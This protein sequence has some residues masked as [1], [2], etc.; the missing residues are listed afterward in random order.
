[1]EGHIRMSTAAT[2]HLVT[3]VVALAAAIVSVAAL[4]IAL[5]GPS[6]A[7]TN[8]A[9]HQG[10]GYSV[11]GGDFVGYYVTTAGTKVY[12]LSPRKALPSGISLHTAA[13]YPGVSKTASRQLAYALNRWGN[14]S[15]SPAAAAE[16]QLVNTI[17]GNAS[18]VAR[19][20]A[21]LPKSVASLVS[22]HLALTRRFYG[23]YDTAVRTPTALLPGQSGTGSVVITS[24][25]GHRVSGVTVL[26]TSSKNGAVPKRITT[27]SK[28]IG[29]FTY[30]ATDVGEV[31]I[32]AMAID[33]PATAVQVN[34]PSPT[35][36][37]M[38]SP[39]SLV[40]SRGSA[41]FRKSP[42][43]FSHS[44][45]CT[46]TCNGKPATTLSACAP[47]SSRA[48][49]IGF[50]Y[51]G[52][53]VYVTFAHS[54]K[55]ACKSRSVTTKDG[56]RVTAGWQFKTSHGW[57]AV[58]AAAGSFVVDCPAVPPVGVS[59]TYDCTNAAVTIGLAQV[60][61]NGMW[62]PLVNTTSHRLVLVIDGKQRIYADR[63]KTALFT[64]SATCGSHTTYT[65]QAGV[66]RANGQYN[67]GLVA[68]VTTP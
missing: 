60:G 24:A 58:V 8:G 33:V 56:D 51:E 54:T 43:G 14:A 48:S 37:H 19:R 4:F 57:S 53:T 2:R 29:K 18:D 27:N 26:L 62:T 68:S 67:Y 6:S 41:S 25:G 5:G 1:M 28:G 49:R 39:V 13:R 22:G 23:P 40:R 44:Y 31:H 10:K 30:R 45:A 47:A 64:A 55:A 36:Q 65:A 66:Q 59:M 21:Q 7:A 17:V 61:A 63:N 16:S 20:A 42:A 34:Q 12:C 32:T 52:K 35:Q 3:T 9:P 46:T 38:V 15:S 11:G 50:R